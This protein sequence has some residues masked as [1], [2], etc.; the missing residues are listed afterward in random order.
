M[1]EKLEVGSC[2]EIQRRWDEQRMR[3][4]LKVQ[5]QNT[6]S[7]YKY[8][9][10]QNLRNNTGSNTG[11]MGSREAGSFVLVRLAQPWVRRIGSKTA[12][13][14][15][16]SSDGQG[17]TVLL[18]RMCGQSHAPVFFQDKRPRLVCSADRSIFAMGQVLCGQ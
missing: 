18:Q 1:E 6:K 13:G 8:S 10:A 7:K 15:K 12:R 11:K 4:G 14:K 9:T 16:L 3:D 5:E 17:R 2:E